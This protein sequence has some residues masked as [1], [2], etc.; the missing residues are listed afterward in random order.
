LAGSRRTGARNEHE[1]GKEPKTRTER[2]PDVP[3]ST[4]RSLMRSNDVGVPYVSIHQGHFLVLL[5]AKLA[6]SFDLMEGLCARWEVEELKNVFCCHSF[7]NQ[8]VLVY[9]K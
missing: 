1:K 2:L 7:G 8:N 3:L 6:A 5:S 4:Y 9:C